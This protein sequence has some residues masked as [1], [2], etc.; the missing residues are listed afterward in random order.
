MIS[1]HNPL[2]MTGDMGAL[3]IRQRVAAAQ[4]MAASF[5]LQLEGAETLQNDETLMPLSPST[6][7]TNC[8]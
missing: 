3:R 7:M 2:E 5:A 6:S 4:E 8:Q 1:H